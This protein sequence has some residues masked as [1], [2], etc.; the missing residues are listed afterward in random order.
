V[1]DMSEGSG[2]HAISH[3]EDS[4]LKASAVLPKD[5]ATQPTSQADQA[6]PTE[7][8]D[9]PAE[10]GQESEN[11]SLLSASNIVAVVSLIL[12][13]LSLIFTIAHNNRDEAAN[14]REEVS[15]QR[16][17]IIEYTGKIATLS[18]DPSGQNHTFEIQAL[19]TQA[20]ALLPN[21]PNV[22]AAIYAQLAEAMINN[23]DNFDTAEMLLNE[24]I[25]RAVAANDIQQQIYSHRLMARI[26][27]R[28]QDLDRL[29]KEYLAAVSASDTYQG[30]HQ[31]IMKYGYGSFTLA[32]WAE[33]EASLK[34]CEE[35][36][37]HLESAREWA[38]SAFY[39][40]LKDHLDA[41][42]KTV[43]KACP[44]R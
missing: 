6:H 29:R 24:S 35:A 23:A 21:V 7:P 4:N 41:T 18:A 14:K 27:Y 34:H 43:I 15:R 11:K 13:A 1:T 40:G 30:K 38:K 19:S 10:S 25:T 3:S 22:P 12:A 2:T 16:A 8:A 33:D 20:V 31:N 9:R 17:E 32:F 5:H 44:T 26:S 39:P 42:Q 37:A 28:D 36:Y